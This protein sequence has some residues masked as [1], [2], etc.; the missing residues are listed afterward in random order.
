M[1]EQ[2]QRLHAL[3]TKLHDIEQQGETNES[4]Q[5]QLQRLHALRTKLHDMEQ[6]EARFDTVPDDPEAG[7]DA[8]YPEHNTTELDATGTDR[9]AQACN[10]AD[11]NTV[12]SCDPKTQPVTS[13]LA[14]GTFERGPGKVGDETRWEP[15]EH[16][17]VALA[18]ALESLANEHL[19]NNEV[20]QGIVTPIV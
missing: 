11:T 3:R 17:R 8:L 1:Q 9:S 15:S 2:V 14:H 6:Q 18:S 16:P 5:E 12:S 10:R 20:A 19:D 4:V 7:L 13:S